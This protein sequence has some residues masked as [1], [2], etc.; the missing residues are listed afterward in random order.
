MQNR[1]KNDLKEF[2]VLWRRTSVWSMSWAFLKCRTK[3]KKKII[4]ICSEHSE[5]VCCES[6]LLTRFLLFCFF[7]Y[8]LIVA[9]FIDAQYSF[10][11]TISW[12]NGHCWTL[13]TKRL[14]KTKNKKKKQNKERTCFLL[15]R[16]TIFFLIFSTL[17]YTKSIRSD[18]FFSSRV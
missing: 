8:W 1:K 10:M 6:R 2:I 13:Q 11:R 14:R 4:I 15:S 3:A 7:F 5:W 16:S 9:A 17:Y 18:I 12:R